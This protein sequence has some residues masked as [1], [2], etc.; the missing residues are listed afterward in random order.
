MTLASISPALA[1][2]THGIF[3]DGRSARKQPV[4]L[5]LSAGH[6]ELDGA[7]A[8]VSYPFDQARM[9]EPFANTPC[10]LDF[11][12]GGRLEIHDRGVS[13]AVQQAL[14][15][16]PSRIERWQHRWYVA[17]FALLVLGASIFAAVQWG[18]PA[19]AERIVPA[20]PASVDKQLGD[21]ALAALQDQMFA[22]SRLGAARI[23]EVQAIFNTVRPARTRMPL[24]LM[25]LNM[26]GK[27][28]NAL[29]LPNGV[30]IMTDEM[31]EFIL[32]DAKELD[33]KMTAQ[34]AG[35]L[36]HEIGHI[37]GRHAMWSVT[38]GSLLALGSAALFG[39]F[40]AVVAGLPALMINLDYSREMEHASDDYAVVRLRQLGISAAPLADLF[41]ALEKAYAV[42]SNMPK[43]LRE[44]SVYLSSHPATEERSARFRGS[45]LDQWEEA[46]PEE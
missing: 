1:P 31:V 6:I 38:R 30:I 11:A 46:S 19:A 43:W 33:D 7:D 21:R 44:Q 8:P 28:P 34:L 12:D 42:E 17:L 18:V 27:P 23:A 22:P 10:V 13:G 2:S 41:D 40:S 20:L 14:G 35:I 9:A 16:R 26:K 15:Y 4:A 29:A 32:G 24:K 45:K 36:A 39:D 37:E 5:N 3:F 25:V